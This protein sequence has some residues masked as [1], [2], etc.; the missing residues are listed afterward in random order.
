MTP[1]T[2]KQANGILRPPE[3]LTDDQCESISSFTGQIQ[4]GNLDGA[5][6]FSV[7]WKPSLEELEA[8]ALGEPVFLTVI[9]GMPPHFLTVGFP[10]GIRERFSI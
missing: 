6:T 10:H 9:G 8:I 3:D 1:A 5:P 4:G 7:A 2:F